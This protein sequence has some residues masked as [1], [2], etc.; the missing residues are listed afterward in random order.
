MS[1]LFIILL[2]FFQIWMLIDSIRREHWIWAIFIGISLFTHSLGISAILY[3]FFVYRTSGGSLGLP[4][5]EL[6]G[7]D[8]RSR[9]RELE[10]Q[11]H[12]L[13]KAH[14]YAELGSIYLKQGNLDKA[15]E[16]LRAAVSRESEEVDY[17]ANLGVCLF[18]KGQDEEAKKLL[19][20]VCL[21]NEDHDYGNTQMI[22]AELLN[23][24]GHRDE[25]IE[26]WKKVEKNHSY[27][28]VKVSLALIYLEEKQVQTAKALL[29][30]VISDDIHAPSFQRNQEKRWVQKAKQLIK[31]YS[32]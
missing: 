4:R 18:E 27:A 31:Q 25:A 30:E 1:N 2:L 17:Q 23:R 8:G 11:I 16:H 14:H 15:E 26:A 22:F 24:M 32:D 7:K 13:D 6:P 29:Q 21:Q 3:Y 28:Q 5:F 10:N 20:E 12:N 19:K 9:I